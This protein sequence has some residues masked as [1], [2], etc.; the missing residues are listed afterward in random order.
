[1]LA[2]D[3]PRIMSDVGETIGV[4]ARNVTALVDALEAD[5]LV[6]RVAHLTDRRATVLELT[7]D[8]SR[9]HG[10]VFDDHRQS[11][12]TLFETLPPADQQLLLQIIE[13]LTAELKRRSDG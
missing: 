9:L 10:R 12:A 11:M 7:P 2:C 4:T 13:T 8:G 3:G 6:R 1:M 5:G